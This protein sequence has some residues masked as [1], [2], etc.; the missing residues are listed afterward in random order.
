MA[1]FQD[2]AF[3]QQKFK[4]SIMRSFIS[5]GCAPDSDG[6]YRRYCANINKG[7]IPI[8]PTGTIAKSEFPD[9]DEHFLDLVNIVDGDED[10]NDEE[11]E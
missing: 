7:S 3:V 11:L 8:I 1:I 2:G 9:D 6:N 5:T 4:E 10:E